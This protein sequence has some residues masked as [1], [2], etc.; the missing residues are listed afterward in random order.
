MAA[1]V[2]PPPASEYA[3]DPAIAS[4]IAF[5]P[6]PNCSNSY[7]PTGPF[8][9]MVPESESRFANAAA[10]R[11]PISRIMSSSS[12]SAAGLIAA[13]A[14]AENSF[15]QTTSTGNGTSLPLSRRIAMIFVASPTRSGSARDLPIFMPAAS[16]K[17][18]AIPPPGISRSTFSASAPRTASFV[19]T[20]AP[21]T[22]ATKGRAGR[23]SALD[24]ASISAA[25]NGP[26]QAT[27]AYFAMPCVLASARCAAPKASL[28]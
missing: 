9:T 26:A 17:V 11:G 18:L 15:A 21:A 10:V 24:S 25:I 22:I 8:Q 20:F 28:T 6:C 27:G 2:S 23:W 19:D 3:P 14:V 1:S 16:M 13:L 12:I 5:V 7:T 4:A